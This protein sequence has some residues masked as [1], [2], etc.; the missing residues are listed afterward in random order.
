MLSIARNSSRKSFGLLS[1]A[2]LTGA[3]LALSAF[4]VLWAAETPAQKTFE[5]PKMAAK[6]LINAAKAN[7]TKALLAIFGPD[8]KE[9]VSSGNEA[10]DKDVRDRF[11]KASRQNTLLIPGGTDRFIL[12]VGKNRWPFPIPIVKEGNAWRFDTASGKEELLNRRI[13]RNELHTMEVCRAYVLV[14]REYFAK[15]RDGDGTLEY[16]QKIPSKPAEMDGLFWDVAKKGQDA[17]PA[18]PMLAAAAET[19]ASSKPQAPYHG[20]FF[21]ILTQQGK[22]AP[23]GEKNYV[24][25]ENMTGGFALLAYPAQ[26]GVTGITTFMVNQQGI[27]F[28]KDLGAKT[29]EIVKGIAKYDPDDTWA[30]AQ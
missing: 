7:D 3:F 8:G 27:V 9:L 26:Y 22:S 1:L 23:G 5:T 2:V 29:D 17:P 14:Q 4:Q 15:D 21:R 11:V 28:E 18:G 12:N 16:A 19:G 30:P 13:G 25:S 10:E 24:E 20:Y 6:A